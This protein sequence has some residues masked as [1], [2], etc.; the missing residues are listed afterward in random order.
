MSCYLGDLSIEN[1]RIE[2]GDPEAPARDRCVLVVLK[3]SQDPMTRIFYNVTIRYPQYYYLGCL[4]EMVRVLNVMSQECLE[5]HCAIEER[6]QARKDLILSYTADQS[7]C[8][9]MD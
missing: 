6:Y 3:H 8:E 2:Q 7:S 1:K 4:E 5:Y 9:G